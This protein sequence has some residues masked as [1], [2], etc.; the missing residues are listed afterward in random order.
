MIK[1]GVTY[2]FSYAMR[3]N[4]ANKMTPTPCNMLDF[5]NFDKTDSFLK[6]ALNI[7]ILVNLIV[8]W[9]EGLIEE[10]AG[11]LHQIYRFKRVIHQSKSWYYLGPSQTSK[12]EFFAQ[13][14]FRL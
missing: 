6:P 5:Q 10:M 2:Q 8:G 14:V 13:I 12:M 7:L 3:H 1:G 9:V 11:I 4:D